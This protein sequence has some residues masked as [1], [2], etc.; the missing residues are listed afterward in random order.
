M[1][2]KS[3]D[4]IRYARRAAVRVKPDQI[5]NFLAK[6]RNDIFPNLKSQKG[7]RRMYLLRTPGENEFASLTLWNNK[8]FADAYGSSDAFTNNTESIREFLESDIS[9]TQFDVDL[10]DVNAEALPPPRTALRRATAAKR[11]KPKAKKK[12]KQKKSR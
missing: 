4:E 3:S 1:S 8:S 10:H 7:I 5:D 6:M 9:V 12:G 11:Q 2:A